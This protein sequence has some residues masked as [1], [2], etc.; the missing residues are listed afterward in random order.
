MNASDTT[1]EAPEVLSCLDHTNRDDCT[2]SVKYRAALS[3]SGKSFPR[4]D[5]AWETRLDLQAGINRRYPDS[6]T[7]PRG[8]DPTFAGEEWDEDY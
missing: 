5:G 8:F 4:C 6:P 3:A 2:G 1:A 7:P